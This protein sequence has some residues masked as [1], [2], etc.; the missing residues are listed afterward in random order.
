MFLF[1]FCNLFHFIV[2]IRMSN[3]NG[4]DFCYR[5]EVSKKLIDDIKLL[6]DLKS[7]KRN[8]MDEIIRSYTPYV[9][10]VVY[11]T[12][13]RIAPPQ[14]IEEVIADTF[15]ALWTHSD[16][17]EEKEGC[18]RAYIGAIARNMAKNKLRTVILCEELDENTVSDMYD[19]QSDLI[20]NEDK[21]VLLKL[22]LSLGEPDS[23]IFIRHYYY[24]EKIKHIS[25]IMG[26]KVSTVKSKLFRGKEKLKD[27]LFEEGEILL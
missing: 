18:I 7:K 21:A 8:C 20:K 1:I 12:I 13:G 2:Y 14:D 4:A 27:K 5:K 9:S 6:R 23:E 17:I 19:P 24:E 10:V 22:I 26:I 15:F 3:K 11:N 25:K 16:S